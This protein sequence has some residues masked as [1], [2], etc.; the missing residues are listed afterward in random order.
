MGLQ[1]KYQ[2]MNIL[3]QLLDVAV[4]KALWRAETVLERLPTKNQAMIGLTLVVCGIGTS[5]Y[6]LHQY[7]RPREPP[8]KLVIDIQVHQTITMVTGQN[9]MNL[10]EM[11]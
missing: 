3:V 2:P 1:G 9:T 5:A 8:A 10:N 4:S 6:M 11:D 7:T